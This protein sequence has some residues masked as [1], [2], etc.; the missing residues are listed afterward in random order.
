MS[1][2]GRFANRTVIVTGG[3][4]GIG[5]ASCLRFAGEGARVAVFDIDIA[6]TEK[7]VAQIQAAGGTAATFRCDIAN[8]EQVNAAIAA[9][10]LAF[11]PVAVLVNNAG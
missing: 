5:A 9:S 1:A 2:M 7:V 10:E 4:G 6:A 8:R 11:G 3:G